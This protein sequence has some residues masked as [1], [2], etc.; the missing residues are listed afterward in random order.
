MSIPYEKHTAK[1]HAKELLMP[2]LQ[3]IE[4]TNFPVMTLRFYKVLEKLFF[5]FINQE[6]RIKS[7]PQL[8]HYS[9]N[10]FKVIIN[11]RSRCH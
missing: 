5:I 1:K 9:K 6:N 2:M 7:Q 8:Y 4:K 10:S 11:G 3:R